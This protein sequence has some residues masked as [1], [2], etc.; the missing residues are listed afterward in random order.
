MSLLSRL[1]RP[2]L[3]TVS[4]CGHATSIWSSVTRNI[5]S[6]SGSQHAEPQ[7]AEAA[8]TEPR[9]QRELGVIRT[10]WT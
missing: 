8:P 1:G 5:S 4:P 3:C 9:W 10:D 7:L 6:T 2:L